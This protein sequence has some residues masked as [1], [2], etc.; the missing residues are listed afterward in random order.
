MG[1]VEISPLRVILTDD[2][3]TT[4]RTRLSTLF[5]TVQVIRRQIHS[6]T[7]TKSNRVFINYAY[8]LHNYNII[9]DH[10]KDFN[11]YSRLLYFL[12]HLKND[13]SF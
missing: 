4:F 12:L 9:Y 1:T 11:A 10:F 8:F 13:H 2:R 6:L 5:E 3:F 7:T